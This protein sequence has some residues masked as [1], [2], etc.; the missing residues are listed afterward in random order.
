MVVGQAV[1]NSIVY[2]ELF[3]LHGMNSSEHLMLLE[4]KTCLEGN[5]LKVTFS[6][7]EQ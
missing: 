3:G 4:E 7:L 2:S 5:V 6:L 1:M